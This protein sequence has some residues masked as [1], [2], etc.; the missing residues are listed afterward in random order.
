MT[1]QYLSWQ[2]AT[3]DAVVKKSS[4]AVASVKN[5]TG[6]PTFSMT[7]SPI[8]SI[9]SKTGEITIT[10]PGE[11]GDTGYSTRMDAW[12]EGAV[13]TVTATLPS[14]KKASTT[15]TLVKDLILTVNSSYVFR[16]D[17]NVGGFLNATNVNFWVDANKN[18]TWFVTVANDESEYEYCGEESSTTTHYEGRLAM[19][20]PTSTVVSY[21][22]CRLFATSTY[23]QIIVI[24]LDHNWVIN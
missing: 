16:T 20:R 9:D 12:E 23:G 7:S 6:T 24:Y 14:G 11:E 19:V 22:A 15:I 2:N 4:K 3:S 1:N 13:L 10:A 5:S 21:N 17:G 18:V 8:A